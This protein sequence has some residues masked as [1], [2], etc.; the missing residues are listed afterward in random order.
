MHYAITSMTLED[1][2][3]PAYCTNKEKEVLFSFNER[4]TKRKILSPLKRKGTPFNFFFIFYLTLVIRRKNLF[5]YI[6]NSP[7]SKIYHILILFNTKT[8]FNKLE[9]ILD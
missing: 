8:Y 3:S 4:G 1:L 6:L 5:I 2:T 9:M 7:S